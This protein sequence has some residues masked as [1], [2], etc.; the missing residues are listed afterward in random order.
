MG[1]PWDPGRLSRAVKAPFPESPRPQLATLS[2]DV[3]GGDDWLHEIKYDGY[4]LLCSI[5]GGRARLFSRG[6]LDWTDKL[7]RLASSARELLAR[8]AVLDGEVVILRPDGTF[9][10]QALQKTMGGGNP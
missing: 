7:S 4:R 1:A 5:Q 10:F 3:P 2:K 8:E 9:D 6:G